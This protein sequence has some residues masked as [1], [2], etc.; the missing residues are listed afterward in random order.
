M[1]KLIVTGLIL[2]AVCLPGSAQVLHVEE[3]LQLTKCTDTTCISDQVLVR[4]FYF[5]RSGITAGGRWYL[6][7]SNEKYPAT[8]DE[9]FRI[10]NTVIIALNNDVSTTVVF[11]TPL[12]ETH[13]MLLK[14]LA[15]LNFEQSHDQEENG[16]RT[17]TF[18]SAHE[19]HLFAEF[20]TKSLPSYPSVVT[21]ELYLN[22]K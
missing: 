2:A 8:S 21:H 10:N 22:P 16:V 4:G 9:A 19:E 15:E 11:R 1:R 20:H 3:L 5:N 18:H 13:Q 17:I 6:Y 14:E 7:F 12:E